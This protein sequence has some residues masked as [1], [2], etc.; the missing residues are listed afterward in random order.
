MSFSE[1]WAIKRKFKGSDSNIFYVNHVA[2]IK[3]RSTF[4]ME[5]ETFFKI[6]TAIYFFFKKIRQ[7]DKMQFI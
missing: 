3:L 6:F 5:K 7:N 1:Y 4:K 2:L